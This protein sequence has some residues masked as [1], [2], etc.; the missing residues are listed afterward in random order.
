M[1][2]DSKLR[3]FK[4]REKDESIK[5]RHYLTLDYTSDRVNKIGKQISNIIRKVTPGFKVVLAFKSIR[6]ASILTSRLKRKLEDKERSGLIYTDE[7][8]DSG[9]FFQLPALFNGQSRR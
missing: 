8:N 1:T 2:L 3:H 6:L 7:I 4:P 9:S 5:E